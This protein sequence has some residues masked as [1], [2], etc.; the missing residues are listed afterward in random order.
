MDRIFSLFQGANNWALHKYPELPQHHQP[1][2]MINRTIGDITIEKTS[3]VASGKKQR[4]IAGELG[5]QLPNLELKTHAEL[6]DAR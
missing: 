5:Y 6:H 1:L 3:G 2:L 4:P